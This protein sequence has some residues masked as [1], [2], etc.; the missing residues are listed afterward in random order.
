M[1]CWQERLKKRLSEGHC[2]L[3]IRNSRLI[4]DKWGC[5]QGGNRWV[6]QVEDDRGNGDERIKSEGMG[7][8][9]FGYGAGRINGMFI[10]LSKSRPRRCRR[11][12][13]L[14]MWPVRR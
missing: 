12:V 6:R 3:D 7:V 1:G 5:R 4:K 14:R 13:V 8:S 9:L 2:L 10:E 11:R